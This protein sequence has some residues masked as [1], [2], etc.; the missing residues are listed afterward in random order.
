MFT[1]T[2][3]VM[4]VCDDVTIAT[5]DD[6]KCADWIAEHYPEK[7]VVRVTIVRSAGSL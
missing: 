2:Y 4:R 3:W 1:T 7:C 6:K 5:C